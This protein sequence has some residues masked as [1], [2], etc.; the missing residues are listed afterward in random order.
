MTYNTLA[1]ILKYQKYRDFDRIYTVYTKSLGKLNIL[2]RGANKIKSKLA[3]HLEPGVLANLMIAQGRYWEI[4]AQ[5]KTKQSFIR[6][7]QDPKLFK[8]VLIILE[9]LDKL[10]HVHHQDQD[11]FNFLLK[12]LQA[13]DKPKSCL[14]S[15]QILSYYFL[16]LLI[17]LGHA[18]DLRDQ[19]ILQPLLIADIAQDAIIVSNKS[20]KLIYQYLLRALDEKRLLSLNC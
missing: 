18:P 15:R 1:V 17:Y 16:H 11:V 20:R 13:I 7:R 19:P 5:A 2:A 4:L 8:I 12:I 10:T 14:T 9:S 6:L 3:G